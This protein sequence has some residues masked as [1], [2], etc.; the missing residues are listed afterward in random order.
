MDASVHASILLQDEHVTCTDPETRAPG[1]RLDLV[2]ARLGR[3]DS[4]SSREPRRHSESE[5]D[6]RIRICHQI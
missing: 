5:R 2:S 1:S 4:D 6:G 3:F